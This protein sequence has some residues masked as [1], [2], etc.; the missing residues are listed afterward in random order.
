MIETRSNDFGH[1]DRKIAVSFGALVLALMLTVAVVAYFLY[2]QLQSKEEDRLCGALASMLSES[3]S[4]V[5]FSGKYHM[6][7]LVEQM[8]ARIPVIESISVENADGLIIAHSDP[9]FNEKREDG[10]GVKLTRECL[11]SKKMVVSEHIH[12]SK[13]IKEVLMPYH[14]G[15]DSQVLGVVRLGVNVE[16]ARA[17]QRANFVKLLELI[18]VLMCVAILIVFALSRY[19]GRTVRE[20]AMQLQA[21]L[22]N[23]PAL[24]YMKDRAGRYLFVNRHWTQLFQTTNETA[25]GKTDLDIFPRETAL[26]LM[27]NDRM[28]FESGRL[29]ELEENAFIEGGMRYY[30]SIK[31][32]LKGNDGN[33]YALCGISTDITEKKRSEEELLGHREHLEELV[34]ERTVQLAMAK[35]NAEAANRAKSLFLANMSHEFRTPMNAILGFAHIMAR[36]AGVTRRQKENLDIIIKS[37]EHLL[38]LINDILDIAK[39]ESGRMQVEL[40]DFDLGELTGDL[41]DMLRVKVEAKGLKLVLDQSSSFPRFVRTD[42]A[43]LRQIIINLVGNAVKFTDQGQITIKLG[44]CSILNGRAG[45]FL[46][47]EIQDTGIGMDETGV[48]NIFK[49]FVQLGQHE[50]TG[51]G[52]AITQQYINLMGGFIEVESQPGKGS[53]FIFAV[54]FE[55]AERDKIK[56]SAPPRGRV[57]QIENAK[58]YKVLI[59]EDQPENRLLMQNLLSPFGFQIAE[60][61]DGIE[62]VALFEKFSPHIIFIDRRMPGI[63]GIEAVCKIRGKSGADGVI[64]IAVTAHAFK[65]ERQQMIDAGCDDFISKPFGADAIFD[66][67]EKYLK[68]RV[69]RDQTES[70]DAENTLKPGAEELSKL[71]AKMLRELEDALIKLDMKKIEQLIS[72][73]SVKI[74]CRYAYGRRIRSAAHV[75]R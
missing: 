59:V 60:A 66:V 55:P 56:M 25:R 44:V 21:I 69:I 14:G 15:F 6:R 27:E 58:N 49:P 16:D 1:A 70:P 10:A 73:I 53:K 35:E 52:L 23:S 17:E 30:Q 22:D 11:D 40:S 50:G 46:K 38:T 34:R 29:T 4:K 8:K 45:N 12:N 65:E 75:Q 19:F 72:D 28:V 43:K 54:S 9:A 26:K 32:A 64:I 13:I 24:I 61:S 2:T 74:A 3:I 51:L 39:I 18:T 47:F 20:L 41:M 62:G 37:G 33:C 48:K 36:D 7:L 68:L 5:S 57:L 71:P 31:V 42:M 67:L 63:D